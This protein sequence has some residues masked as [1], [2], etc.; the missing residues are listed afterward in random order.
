MGPNRGQIKAQLYLCTQAR[1][2]RSTPGFGEDKIFIA[3]EKGVSKWR[4]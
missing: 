3:Q 2:K 4:V 1:F